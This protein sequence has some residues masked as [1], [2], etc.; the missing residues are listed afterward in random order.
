MIEETLLGADPRISSLI[1]RQHSI[2]S[3]DPNWFYDEKD[4]FTENYKTQPPSKMFAVTKSALRVD[5]EKDKLPGASS[6][7]RLPSDFGN[8]AAEIS[9]KESLASSVEEKASLS[10]K[11]L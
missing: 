9:Y 10:A 1:D 7:V 5:F 3:Q 2:C 8:R 4:S 11:V 6:F